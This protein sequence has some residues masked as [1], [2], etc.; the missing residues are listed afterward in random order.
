MIIITSPVDRLVSTTWLLLHM[1][2][3]SSKSGGHDSKPVS[4]DAL[5]EER[6]YC[7]SPQRR[8]ACRMESESVPKLGVMQSDR[9]AGGIV[10][11]GFRKLQ[12][13]PSHPIRA[14]TYEPRA[15][16]WAG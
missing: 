3:G 12:S 16:I 2:P 1:V 4:R 5:S 9:S 13:D 6:Q 14:A 11:G 10:G 15:R 8:A 7:R